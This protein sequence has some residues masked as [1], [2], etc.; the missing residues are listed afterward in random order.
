MEE[1]GL[2][3]T[4]LNAVVS[5]LGAAGLSSQRSDRGKLPL[6]VQTVLAQHSPFHISIEIVAQTVTTDL[7]DDYL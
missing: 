1:G 5:S 7:H 2:L 3:L 6:S 4:G